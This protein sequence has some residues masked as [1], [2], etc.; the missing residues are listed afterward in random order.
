MDQGF[1]LAHNLSSKPGR[2]GWG[3]RMKYVIAVIKPHKLEEVREALSADGVQGITVSEVKGHGRQ[4]GHTE[5]YRGAE[6]KVSF[7]PKVRLDIA[8]DNSIVDRVVETIK[9]KG[10]TGQIG[11][12]K[13]FV[14]PLEQAV[15]IRTGETGAAAL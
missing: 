12:G 5:F 9:T 2:N 7:V 10:Q 8:V 14:L 11:D 3:M 13:I 4:G 1:E 6:Y 15:R